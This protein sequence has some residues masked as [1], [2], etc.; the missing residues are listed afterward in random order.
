M[1]V[2]AEQVCRRRKNRRKVRQAEITK[3][4]F[5]YLEEEFSSVGETGH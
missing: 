3:T 5:K 1:Q 2:K 4:C